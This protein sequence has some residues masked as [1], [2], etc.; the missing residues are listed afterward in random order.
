M[1][2]LVKKY[3]INIIHAHDYLPG[4]SAALTGVFSRTPVVVTFHL[5]VQYTTFY[6]PSYL[7]PFILIEKVFK[8]CF[9]FWVGE[10]ICVSK[11][12]F[13]ETL[14]LGFPISKLKLIYNW[15]PFS[16]A[17]D[18]QPTLNTLR[19][20]NL[21]GKPY[22]LSVGRLQERQKCFS[23]LIHAFKLLLNK[24]H[25]LDLVIVGG[26]PDKEAYEKISLRNHT[27]D[28][29]H[30]FSNVAK[31]D[32]ANLYKSCVLFVFPSYLEGLPLAL[33]EAMFYGKPIV[34]TMVGGIPE[35]IEDGYNGLLVNPD[36]NSILLAMEK[37]LLTPGL[38]ESF[39]RRSKEVVSRKFSRNNMKATIS[40]F[41]RIHSG[42]Q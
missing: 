12:T 18:Q 36:S 37:M 14:K 20:F 22:V 30:F 29:I 35:V 31:A 15:V 41:E 10:I 6:L 11:F 19:K 21:S 13:D 23:I 7:S 32:L 17:Q 16:P 2:Y 27:E 34:A 24:G 26:G 8:K 3:K 28:K 5:P 25:K 38:K 4:L 42:T 9:D 39:G 40:L 1:L 33:L